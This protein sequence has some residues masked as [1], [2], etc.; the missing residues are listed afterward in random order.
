MAEK[1][2][3]SSKAILAERIAYLREVFPEAF[4][5]GKID[6]DALKEVLGEEVATDRERYGLSWA[7]K[8]EA[9]RN[10][11]TP[12]VGTL[13][14]DREESV[15][16]YT[17][18]NLFLE[19]D[20]LE[21]LKLLQKSY[22]GRVKM[23]YIDPPYNTGN[24]FIYP[25]NFRE[26]LE[27]YLRYSGQVSGDGFKLSTSTET[28]GR[29][30]SKWLN[31]M[32]P[33]LVLA[34][35]L[36][37]D[38]GVIFV[39]IDDHE[40]H[41]LR[42]LMNEVFGA[43]NFVGMFVW[44][45]KKGGGSDNTSVVD[46]EYVVCFAKTSTLNALSRLTLEAEALDKVDDKGP[47]RRGRELNMWGANSRREDR[48]KMYF[49]IPGPN[50]EEVY[51]IRNDG[52]EGCWRWG[53]KKMFDVVERGDV[54]FV[55]RSNGTHIVYEKIRS[56]DPRSKPYRTWLT[57]VG[58][59]ADG[60]KTVKELF[61]GRKVYDFPKPVRLLSHLISVG[62]IGG[63]E[64]I[65]LDFFAGSCTTAH[66]V[67]HLNRNDG[68]D[69]SFICVQLPESTPEDSEARKA[70]YEALVEVGKERIRRV[71]KEL[72]EEDQSQLK[73]EVEPPQDRG[74]KDFKLT[75]SNFKIWD[76]TKDTPGT[77]DKLAEQLRA[78]ANN[79]KADRSREEILY[80]ILLKAG[81]PLIAPIDTIDIAG[82]QVCTAESAALLI[83][84]AESVNEELLRGMAE[85][86]PARVV[87]LETAF[88]GNDQLKTNA[89]LEM[90]NRGIEFWTV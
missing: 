30:H 84:L 4:T 45:S 48:P 58:T 33:R 44:Q 34:R 71:I 78:F 62:T 66:A 18:E 29:Y 81:F 14:P 82:E 79:V 72:N 70:G 59:T 12:S 25:D 15:N 1:M 63:D 67:M 8:S 7:G 60:S 68:G 36:L 52:V 87:C 89:V 55:K 46:Q 57:D 73:T 88:H 41:N 53:K 32:Y 56:T 80:E 31:M 47:Y 74:F 19:G 54:E 10:V 76:S 5:E 64:V 38:D 20:N 24:E 85:L 39:S 83:C 23:I 3:L 75:S 40:V 16:F 13:V 26:D 6:F 86:E 49:P 21:V 37:R 69:R 42:L 17:T 35:N 90:K 61:D 51:P 28:S 2:A 43:E 77:E 22:H 11:Q 9:I 27:D 50:G 65:V